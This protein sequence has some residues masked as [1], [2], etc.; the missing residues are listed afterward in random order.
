MVKDNKHEFALFYSDL[1]V[2]NSTHTVL[3]K[4][5]SL[6]QRISSVLRLKAGDGLILFNQKIHAQ[7]ELKDCSKKACSVLVKT[8]H[9]NKKLLPVITVFLPLLK[10][11]AFESA[12]YASTALG[13]TQIQLIQT[14][15]TRKW[16]GQKELER[17]ERIVIAAAEQSK[18]FN[19]PFILPPCPLQEALKMHHN[20]TQK[21]FADPTGKHF[22]E[23]LKNHKK[24]QDM[25]LFVGP[26]GDLT[27]SEK[28]LLKD[29]FVFCK[30]T[31]TILKSEQAL[32]LLLGM[33]R[34]LT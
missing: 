5:V 28:Q 16:Q 29:A 23:I 4:D 7:V 10:R 18:N 3:I 2:E 27:T 26:E 9:N 8:W 13:A 14:E 15:K 32:A 33:V 24:E 20:V 34:S 6:V 11:D 25:L 31:P 21:L 19:F 1:P 22:S 17:L 30:L 12:L